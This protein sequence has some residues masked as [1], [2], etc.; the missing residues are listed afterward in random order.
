M[1]ASL[2]QVAVQRQKDILGS[3]KFVPLNLF[4]Y[5]TEMRITDFLPS[6]NLWFLDD[7]MALNVIICVANLAMW[8]CSAKV[9]LVSL[10]RLSHSILHNIQLKVKQ[11]PY[12]HPP[13]FVYVRGQFCSPASLGCSYCFTRH[14]CRCLQPLR[15]SF[16]RL[17]F[18]GRI[19]LARVR[20]RGRPACCWRTT[21]YRLLISSVAAA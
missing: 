18:Y 20:H 21:M 8:Q 12:R 16:L 17:S 6:Q 7:I 13:N 9:K 1:F 3:G 5:D 4:Y 2:A 11:Y 19:V 15:A 10:V 14:L